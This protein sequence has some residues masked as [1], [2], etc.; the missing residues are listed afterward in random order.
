MK[1]VRACDHWNFM[2]IIHQFMFIFLQINVWCNFFAL[3][4]AESCWF[5]ADSMFILLHIDDHL[6]QI[7]TKNI[8]I[9]TFYDLLRSKTM[10]LNILKMFKIFFQQVWLS[11]KIHF[12]L[13]EKEYEASQIHGLSIVP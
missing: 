8:H 6:D 7:D 13:A 5:S 3:F 10:P 12:Q 9:E 11:M 4:H 1:T 2:H